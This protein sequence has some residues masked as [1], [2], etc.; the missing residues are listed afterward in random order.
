MKYNEIIRQ[1][2]NLNAQL[3]RIHKRMA[4][5]K[6]AVEEYNRLNDKNMRI[7]VKLVDLNKL[8]P[9]NIRESRYKTGLK[10]L[11]PKAY[12]MYMASIKAIKVVKHD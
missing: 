4:A 2:R 1:E 8:L 10:K 6:P 7:F 5:L 9:E 11:H 3:R 12:A